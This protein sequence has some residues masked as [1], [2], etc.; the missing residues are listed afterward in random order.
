MTML[1]RKSPSPLDENHLGSGA[2]GHVYVD[3][4]C[5]QTAVKTVVL[6]DE[7]GVV[8]KSCL[9]DAAFAQTFKRVEIKGTVQYKKVKIENN[10]AKIYMARGTSDLQKWVIENRPVHAKEVM[11]SLLLAIKELHDMGVSHGDL[12]PKNIIVMEND[13][14]NLRIVDFGAAMYLGNLENRDCNDYRHDGCTYGFA[15]PEMFQRT[16][17]GATSVEK[18]DCWSIGA[19]MFFYMTKTNLLDKCRLRNG[20]NVFK[21]VSK[22]HKESGG[23]ERRIENIHALNKDDEIVYFAIKQLLKNDVNQRASIEAALATLGHT[24]AD[25]V[26]HIV[27]DIEDCSQTSDMAREGCCFED[28]KE[29]AKHRDVFQKCIEN[30]LIVNAFDIIRCCMTSNSYI[31]DDIVLETDAAK[32]ALIYALENLEYFG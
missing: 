1:K 10:T 17:T 23:V 12:K 19:I 2:Y 13:P 29:Y 9:S 30:S 5:H 21:Q 16:L 28:A 3:T 11:I 24:V 31:D 14:R 7:F 15:P 4:E 22:F 18:F 6:Y 25:V 20:D 26:P 32:N 27:A 8:N